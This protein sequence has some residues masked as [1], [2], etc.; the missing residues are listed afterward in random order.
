M[1]VQVVVVHQRLDDLGM[2][3]INVRVARVVALHHCC[4]KTRICHFSKTSKL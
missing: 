1:P 3:L 2:D 4:P